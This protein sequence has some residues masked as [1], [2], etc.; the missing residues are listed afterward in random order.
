M[1]KN[2]MIYIEKRFFLGVPPTYLRCA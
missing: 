1:Q 2:W